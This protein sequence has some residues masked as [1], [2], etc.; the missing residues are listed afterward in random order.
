MLLFG[1][2]GPAAVVCTL[3]YSIPPVMRIASH[4]IEHLPATTLEASDS[5]GVDPLAAP[6]KVELP[7][8]NRWTRPCPSS[9]SR[10]R[11][12]RRGLVAARGAAVDLVARDRRAAVRTG[13]L[14]ERATLPLPAVAEL[15]VGAPGAV[16]GA[17]GVAEPLVGARA[18]ADGVDRAHLVVVGRP[19]EHASCRGSDVAVPSVVSSVS[20]PLDVPR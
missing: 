20:P 5:L 11:G 15:S 14:Q 10:C 2:G 17:A 18:F 4:G 1:I 13:A 19:V 16:A 8:A 12:S 6:A 9:P 7:M 3:I